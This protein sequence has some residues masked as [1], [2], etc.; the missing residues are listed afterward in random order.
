MPNQRKPTRAPV[1]RPATKP[2]ATLKV[3]VVG[4]LEVGFLVVHGLVALA[5]VC[6][7]LA[8]VSVSQFLLT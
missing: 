3:L 5:G 8:V 6:G 7:F 1:E 2:A 4:G